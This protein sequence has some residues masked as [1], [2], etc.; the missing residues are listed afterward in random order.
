MIRVMLVLLLSMTTG[1]AWAVNYGNEFAANQIAAEQGDAGA[2]INLANIY[3][4]GQGVVQNYKEASRWYR[5]AAEQ[6]N[7][8]AQVKLANM[9]Y[10]GEVVSVDFIHAYMWFNIASVNG[11]KDAIKGK[12]LMS[13]KMSI[14]GI[15]YAQDLAKKCIANGYKGCE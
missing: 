13:K 11:D 10:K 7:V 12:N 5:L 6:G 9:Y 14:Q 8:E 3:Y 4:K 15:E 1:S 2:Q